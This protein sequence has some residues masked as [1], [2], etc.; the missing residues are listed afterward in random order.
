MSKIVALNRDSDIEGYRETLRAS[1]EISQLRIAELAS[2][3][4]S[5]EF[6]YQ[7]K[8]EAVGC[9]PLDP[10]RQLNLIEQLNQT[11]TYLAS[12]NG[13]EFLFSRHPNVKTLTL[14]LGTKA[15]WDIET[16]DDGGVI[17][18]VSATVAPKNNSKLTKDIKKVASAKSKHRYVLFMSPLHTAGLHSFGYVPAGVVVWSLGSDL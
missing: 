14:N 6:L 15:G 16:T 7:L 8:F 17:A 10:S 18:E 12:F 4:T 11:F 13:A 1:A 2:S 3:A 5:L 9:D